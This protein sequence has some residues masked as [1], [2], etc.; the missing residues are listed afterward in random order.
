MRFFVAG[1]GSSR[2]V[3]HRGIALADPGGAFFAVSD[4]SRHAHADC[5]ASDRH[6]THN[7]VVNLSMRHKAAE[8]RARPGI[9]MCMC[10]AC[11]LR[12]RE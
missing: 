5:G 11:F 7:A 8:V 3:T 6:V 2:V 1:R 12:Y 9:C 10:G 4:L